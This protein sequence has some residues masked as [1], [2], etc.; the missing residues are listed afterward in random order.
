LAALAAL[1]LA[2]CATLPSARRAESPWAALPDD[3]DLYLFADVRQARGLLEP[4]AGSLSGGK[5]GR[6]GPL[7]DRSKEAYACLYLA[8]AAAGAGAAELAVTGRWSPDLVSMRMSF[9]C[10]WV[11][12]EP[13]LP[14]PAS[15]ASTTPPAYWSVRRGALEIGSPARGLLLAAAGRPGALERMMVRRLSVQEGLVERAR[16]SDPRVGPFLAGA[17]LYACLPAAGKVS[18]LPMHQL[19]LA[20]RREA[21]QY[22]LGAL[23]S[24]AGTPNPRALAALVR[25][26][27]AAL[28]RKASIPEV[29]A[30]L[31]A[32]EITAEA[33]G[34]TVRG[35][36]LSETELLA[37]LRGA[38][39][40]QTAQAAEDAG[41]AGDADARSGD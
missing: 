24:L 13:A 16:A 35:L 33:E 5:P 8:D 30:R 10:G 36:K 19:W 37:L 39:L 3:G 20:A 38:L 34:L 14:S 26:A 31:R 15:P 27:A 41:D 12:H 29:V 11:R 25:L 18:G 21:D 40:P 9:S 6:L 32:L 17:A 22:E 1:L 23:A 7:L 28:L 2:S 4:L